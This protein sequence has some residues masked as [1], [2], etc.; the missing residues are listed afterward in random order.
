MKFLIKIISILLILIC[1]TDKLSGQ[2]TTT[3][4][5]IPTSNTT[6]LT[7]TTANTTN[8]TINA[9]STTGNTTTTNNTSP[10]KPTI[11][12]AVIVTSEKNATDIYLCNDAFTTGIE[13]VKLILF[14]QN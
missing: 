7:N 14:S 10:T 12:Q 2:N 5:T 4:T 1:L 8:S 6:I 9:N 3:N 11:N 13:I